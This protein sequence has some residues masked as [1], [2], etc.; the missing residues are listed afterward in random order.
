MESSAAR[1]HWSANLR[2]FGWMLAGVTA[3]FTVSE[4]VALTGLIPSLRPVSLR[5]VTTNILF[6]IG[7]GSPLVLHLSSLPGWREAGW[8]VALGAAL[9]ALLLL[10]WLLGREG[11]LASPLA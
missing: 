5:D 7:F 11:G 4:A 3:L 8:S 10:P 2:R 6:A 1:E 9:A